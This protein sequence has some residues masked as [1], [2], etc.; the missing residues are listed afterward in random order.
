MGN[1][2]LTIAPQIITSGAFQTVSAAPADNALLTFVGTAGTAYANSLMF[3]K[4]AFALCMVPMVKPPGSVD[5]SRQSKN[6]ISVRV[7]PYYDGTNDVSN[8][9]LDV[10]YGTKTID[11][12]LAVRVSGT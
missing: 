4:N 12:R 9:R 5:C 7:I 3:H 10:L 6:G 8:W 1:L 2:T 11:P